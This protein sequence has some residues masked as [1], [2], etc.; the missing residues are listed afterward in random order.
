MHL[1]EGASF[2]DYS[3]WHVS[4]NLTDWNPKL[5]DVCGCIGGNELQISLTFHE[6]VANESDRHLYEDVS[7]LI[8]NAYLEVLSSPDRS[9]CR[10][11]WDL[12]WVQ[13]QCHPVEELMGCQKRTFERY[14]DP[15]LIDMNE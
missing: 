7:I 9:R 2:L 8:E 5:E 6:V 4:G 14:R 12:R 11:D 10:T 13:H 1:S 3:Q 15:F